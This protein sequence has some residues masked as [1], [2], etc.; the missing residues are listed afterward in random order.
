MKNIEKKVTTFTSINIERVS[1]VSVA[2]LS[3]F[4]FASVTAFVQTSSSHLTKHLTY[5][6]FEFSLCVIITL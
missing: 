2:N 5:R 6:I 4:E 1:K 3:K